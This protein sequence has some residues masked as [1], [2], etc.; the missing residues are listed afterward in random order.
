MKR[1]LSLLLVVCMMVAL[2]A[3]SGYAA[4]AYDGKTVILYTGN[5]RGNVDVYP[6][7]AAAKKDYE[8]KGAEVILVDAGNYLQG[9]AAANTD[10]GLS[11]YNLMDAAGYDVAGMGLAEFCFT[12]GAVGYIYHAATGG[13]TRYYSQAEL[14]DGAEELT[15]MKVRATEEKATRPAKAAATFQTVCA[16]ATVNA[17]TKAYSFKASQPITTKSGLKIL[18]YGVTDPTVT[19]NLQRGNDGTFL[20]KVDEPKA[21]TKGNNDLLVCL[22]ATEVEDSFGDVVLSAPYDGEEIIGACVIDN[23]T[24]KATQE[25]VTLSAKDAEVEKLAKTAKDNAAEVIGTSEVILNGG[26]WATWKKETNLGDLV[27]DAFVW[28]AKNYVDGIDKDV[29]IVG[30]FNGGNLDQFIY[31]GDVTEVD[32]HNALPFPKGLG[33]IYLTGEQILEALESGAQL[34]K[35]TDWNPGFLHVSNITYTID[36]EAEYDAGEA[37]GDSYYRAKSIN[38]V[39]ITSID[40]KDLD[41]KKTY[42]VVTD[43][44]I[45]GGGD[46]NYIFVDATEAGAKVIDSA[47]KA[48]DVVTLYI[49]KEL[50]GKITD[51]YAV[52]QKRITAPGEIHDTS[53]CISAKFTDV[54]K[55]AEHWTHMP[56][57]YALEKGIM[58]GTSDTTFA[59]NASVTRGMVATILYAQAGKPSVK[60]LKN[61]FTDV[62]TGRYFTDAVIWANSQ[63][64][65]SGYPDKT[66]KPG[67]DITREELV[68]ILRKVAEIG[69][70]DLKADK[71]LTEFKDAGK[72]QNYAK[73][74]MKWA[75]SKGL[76]AGMENKTL[77]PQGTATRAQIATIMMAYLENL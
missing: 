70:K 15:Y 22:A 16:N 59:P 76:I 61:N 45:I 69:K 35:D 63:G 51:R 38:K 37:Y 11:V 46:S 67:K 58:A 24:K 30:M 77:V 41:L 62:A 74:A 26:D 43:N 75:Y 14:Q 52:S 13:Q 8:S 28:Y 60:G 12:D 25:K 57:D 34:K 42:A 6:Q 48:Q 68:T 19:D 71:D 54:S 36:P 3:V 21:I 39:E 29:P 5:L 9:S 50:K 7:I 1:F 66:F 17:E 49:Q 27:T 72:V 10:L 40:G 4:G 73:E 2:V 33:V 56:I 44:L 18:F 32:M 20:D 53:K 65:V 47:V 64:M 23:K 31:T 55:D